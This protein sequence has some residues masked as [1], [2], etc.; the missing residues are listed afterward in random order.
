MLHFLENA[1]RWLLFDN[2][3]WWK[4]GQYE[5]E[6]SFRGCSNDTRDK[7][8]IG[9]TTQLVHDR[10]VIINNTWCPTGGRSCMY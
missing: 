5:L 4:S 6:V 9:G 2:L 10:Q 8:F 1:H 3:G 7:G